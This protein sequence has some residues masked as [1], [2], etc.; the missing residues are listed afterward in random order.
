MGRPGQRQSLT[1]FY[2]LLALIVA[3]YLAVTARGGEVAGSEQPSSNPGDAD[4]IHIATEE[5][6]GDTAPRKRDN[7][8]SAEE[9]MRK[10]DKL[11]AE[12]Q[13]LESSVNS[14]LGG[15]RADLEKVN[16]AMKGIAN[17]IMDSIM[18]GGGGDKKANPFKGMLGSI[19]G[20]LG[21]GGPDQGLLGSVLG[22]MEEEQIKRSADRGTDVENQT[23]GRSKER[24]KEGN[25]RSNDEL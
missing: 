8:G 5:E 17:K 22:G 9:A 21:D 2:I 10:L 4:G 20:S 23:A 6:G 1:E 3:S 15:L 19:L 11:G 24:Q 14:L 13:Q 12:L 7:L 25:V 18:S 16:P